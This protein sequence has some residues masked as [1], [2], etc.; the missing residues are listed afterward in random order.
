MILCTENILSEGCFKCM[1]SVSIVYQRLFLER[2]R[3]TKLKKD[4][5]MVRSG[6]RQDVESLTSET[7]RVTW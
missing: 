1:R 2:L 3:K 7:L 4:L 5:G 6:G